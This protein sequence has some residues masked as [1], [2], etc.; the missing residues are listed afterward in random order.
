MP[1]S[2]LDS[3]FHSSHSGSTPESPVSEIGSDRESN[4]TAPLTPTP[5]PSPTDDVA[6]RKAS[7]AW[8]LFGKV[9]EQGDNELASGRRYEDNDRSAGYYSHA[10]SG[11]DASPRRRRHAHRGEISSDEVSSRSG[12]EGS[13]K[14]SVS[15]G[16]DGSRRSRSYSRNNMRWVGSDGEDDGSEHSPK[17]RQDAST[18]RT[19]QTPYSPRPR[20][21][22][23]SIVSD[24]SDEASDG[25]ASGLRRRR[26]SSRSSGSQSARS[27]RTSLYSRRS[28]RST[29][30]ESSRSDSEDSAVS[31]STSSSEYYHR[32]TSMKELDRARAR[33][34]RRKLRHDKRISAAESSEEQSASDRSQ[35]PA[36]HSAPDDEPASPPVPSKA[37]RAGREKTTVPGLQP[38]SYG[39]I[40]LEVLQDSAAERHEPAFIPAAPASQNPL[41]RGD[42]SGST[43]STSPS[44]TSHD[45]IEL[46]AGASTEISSFSH[47]YKAS[48]LVPVNI[49]GAGLADADSGRIILD[50]D[51]NG[52]AISGSTIDAQ[53]SKRAEEEV[54]PASIP[55]P[56][57]SIDSEMYHAAGSDE[58][59]REGRKGTERPKQEQK[60][61]Q[62]KETGQEEEEGIE[63]KKET[64]RLQGEERLASGRG[65]KA[66]LGAED[67]IHTARRSIRGKDDMRSP[68]KNSSEKRR[69]SKEHA[70][71]EHTS[72]RKSDFDGTTEGEER[73]IAEIRNPGRAPRT[74]RSAAHR[75]ARVAVLCK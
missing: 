71:N 37:R 30:S 54:D 17:H 62:E 50:A 9:D 51:P 18:P 42:L 45:T 40:R 44:T 27:A 31:T 47:T 70:R 36:T 6:A 13:R 69:A 35:S 22:R 75:A 53:V 43:D 59:R 41:L 8:S 1:L 23:S 21:R 2:P 57:G 20:S 49:D 65:S 10:D 3:P 19:P 25:R 5:E 38:I 24:Y 33:A 58:T 39:K 63:R 67:G 16:S 34:P 56:R 68:G 64:K 15:S 7:N 48:D 46:G 11:S 61:K 60:Q 29:G 72:R 4:Y 26:T 66:I 74:P 52:P 14:G 32:R 12:S 28:S 73:K 55:L